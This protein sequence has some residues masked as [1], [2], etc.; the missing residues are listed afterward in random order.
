[1]Q[2]V[3][4]WKILSGLVVKIYNILLVFESPSILIPLKGRLPGKVWAVRN[5]LVGV[6]MGGVTRGGLQTAVTP[7]ISLMEDRLS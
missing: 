4:A 7:C 2:V 3:L 6:L 1:M 5:I